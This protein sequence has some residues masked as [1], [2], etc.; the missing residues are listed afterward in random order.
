LLIAGS[1]ARRSRKPR[2]VRKEAA[3]AVVTPVPQG[4]LAVSDDHPKYMSYKVLARKWRPRQF[5]EIVGQG[6]ITRILT[7]AIQS[8][9]IAHSYLFTGIRGVGKTTAAR[10]LARAL[11]CE[12]GPTPDPCNQCTSCLEISNGNSIDVF[13]IDGATNRG[14]D[15][16]RQIIEN[17]RYQPAKSRYKIYIIDEV[18]QVTKE[19]FNALLKTLEEP[20]PFG[21]FILATTEPHRIPDT[22]LS[23]CQ[24]FDFRRISSRDIARRLSEIARDENLRVT[25]GAL[26]LISREAEGSMRDAQSLLEQVL[27]YSAPTATGQESGVQVDE[28]LLLDILGV[29]ER[30]VLYDLSEAVIKGDPK[31]CIEIVAGVMAQGLDL[32]RLSRELVEQF[33]NLLVA[34]LLQEKGGGGEGHK[35]ESSVLGL[36]FDLPDQ[37]F[38]DLNGQVSE[39][40]VDTLMDYFRVMSDGDLEVA[41]SS[42][43]RFALETT[44]IRLATLPGAIP[45]AEALERLEGLE[46]RLSGEGGRAEVPPSGVTGE[47]G[48]GENRVETREV[49]TSESPRPEEKA[50]VWKKFLAFIMEEKKFLAS[51]LEQVV[52][53][54]LPP[55]KLE[56][57]VGERHQL[58]YLMDPENLTT[59]KDYACRFFSSEVTVIVSSLI[60]KSL[61]SEGKTVGPKQFA[62]DGKNNMVKETLRIFGGSIKEVKK[63]AEY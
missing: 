29:V 63:R 31:R 6:H 47:R 1:C 19:G 57:G 30:K 25:E 27:S 61:V 56:I 50:A 11:N 40:S 35:S 62:D 34:R 9:R 28:Q 60:G 54:K 48:R 5:G 37:E 4:S 45:V 8:N 53:L 13:E 17:I 12:K 24:R 23:R 41:R 58:N 59:L 44:L 3:V 55:G 16:V 49:N 46:R 36:L 33:R 26:L 52:P 10:I 7:N 38:E 39:L 43:P 20:P 22:I 51:H 32:T 14:I 42:Y 2:Q 18:H 15:E 21:K